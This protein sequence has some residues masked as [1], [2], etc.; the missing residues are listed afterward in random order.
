MKRCWVAFVF[1]LACAFVS[2][3]DADANETMRIAI[4]ASDI[5][6]KL[7]Q[8]ELEIP[9]ASQATQ[10]NVAL[11]YPKWVPGS[12]GP[13][14]PI[15]NVAGLRI[16]D[17]K[18]N[19]LAWQ[20]SPGEVYRIEVT[21]PADTD[22]LR[23]WIR[24]I[25]NQPTTGSTGHDSWGSPRIGV[26]TPSTVLLYPE[27]A[28]IDA[29]L[30]ASTVKLP[31]DWKLSS[32]LPT[33][34]SK[35][36]DG[37]E[38]V[39]FKE[40]SLSQFVD[41]PIM[42]GQYRRVLNL[43]EPK[44]KETIPPHRLCLFADTPQQCDI[45][46]VILAR[47]QAMVT[48]TALLCGSHPFDQ[49]DILL[50]VTNNL[51][52]NGLEHSRSTFNVLPPS[53]LGSFA[54]LRGWN[55][56]LVP[57]EYLHAWC[58]KYRRPA[59]MVT[60]N[61]HTPLNTELL[62]VYEGLTQYLGELVEAR[63]GLMTADQFK[64][65]LLVELQNAVHQQGRQWRTLAD[66]GA[67]AHILRDGSNSWPGLRRSQDFYME[68]MLFWLEADAILRTNSNGKKSL[69]DFCHEF[70]SATRDTTLP[71]PYTRDDL[72]R[73]LDSL[74][75][76]DWDGLIRRRVES[77]QSEF[78]PSVA[79]S[80][81]YRFQIQEQSPAIPGDTFRLSGAIDAYD[82][83]GVTFSSDGVVRNILLDS[84]ADKARLAQGMKIVG[85]GS[86]VWSPARLYQAIREAKSGSMIELKIVED[87]QFRTISIPYHDGLRSW[88]LVRDPSSPDRLAEI[89]KPRKFVRVASAKQ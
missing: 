16:E 58:G 61:F 77:F 67:A 36:N 50:A 72:I 68:G 70:F 17:S 29:Q 73:I 25:T 9:I 18:G 43:V 46:A 27:D 14:G 57:H 26:V 8:A 41:S 52:P 74:V 75:S 40:V 59:G 37:A 89:L 15:S 53:A 66:T 4:D 78:D 5:T 24:Y 38:T 85:I 11:W 28:D 12:H 34:E 13:G 3:T 71:N 79:E 22:R 23:V 83:L 86:F 76:Y 10:R 54:Q 81:G 49:F 80:L 2:L 48:Q 60:S 87:E 84:P 88:N 62:W 69:D 51:P 55:R 1:L 32:A 35:A 82:S 7:L 64:H 31:V 47:L 42:C 30:I 65:R 44:H 21:V 33:E 6:R 19:T 39:S 45:D 56:L 20:R 63:C